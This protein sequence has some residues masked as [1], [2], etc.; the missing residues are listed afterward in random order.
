MSHDPVDH[1]THYT[2]GTIEVIDFIEDKELPYHLGNVIKYVVR[3]GKKTTAD[4]LED[5]AKARWYL[6]R[7]I[8]L[9]RRANGQA[10]KNS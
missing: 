4:E 8:E 3:A 6:N 9:R 10:E 2:T 5:L 1:P 7:Y